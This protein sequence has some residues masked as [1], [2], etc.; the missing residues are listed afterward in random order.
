MAQTRR[1]DLAWQN[2]IG[3]NHLCEI[4]SKEIFFNNGKDSK[5]KVNFDHSNGGK[6]HIIEQPTNWLMSRKPKEINIKIWKSC[7][8]GILCWDCNRRLPTLDRTNWLN[9]CNIY[10]NRKNNENIMCMSINIS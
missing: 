10:N 5:F 8:F 9:K 6:E 3:I 4:C 2:I 7:N 1:R